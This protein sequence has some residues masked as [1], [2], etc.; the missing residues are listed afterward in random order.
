MSNREKYYALI[1]TGEF[2]SIGDAETFDVACDLADK[3]CKDND[4]LW[5]YSEKGLLE[6]LSEIKKALKLD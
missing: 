5:I 4:V 2:I 6:H 1:E 3:V